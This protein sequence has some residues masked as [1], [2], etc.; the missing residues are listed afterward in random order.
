M[1]EK[2]DK[3]Y[4]RN[5]IIVTL[6]PVVF[7]FV[8]CFLIQLDKTP[9]I[10]YHPGKIR[11]G[12]ENAQANYYVE[13]SPHKKWADYWQGHWLLVVL[14]F[15]VAGAGTFFYITWV[16]STDNEGSMYPIGAAWLGGILIV[17]IGYFTAHGAMEYFTNLSVQDFD[18]HKDNL[19][20]L[21]PIKK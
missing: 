4:L 17:F 3:W 18:L 16:N 7:M 13:A 11:P 19:D 8:S 5:R 14:G 12:Y 15:V 10:E 20:A 1:A 2:K 6:M 9:E 21:F